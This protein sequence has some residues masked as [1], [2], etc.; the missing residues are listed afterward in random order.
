[1]LTIWHNLEYGIY[2]TGFK[3]VM[4]VAR[5]PLPVAVVFT[6]DE[7]DLH[8]LQS[9]YIVARHAARVSRHAGNTME[10]L[11]MIGNQSED[12]GAVGAPA[13]RVKLAAFNIEFREHRIETDRYVSSDNL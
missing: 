7:L 13:N 5:G 2:A 9:V 6:H 11:G 3:F 1:M 10:S 8:G 4:R 12:T